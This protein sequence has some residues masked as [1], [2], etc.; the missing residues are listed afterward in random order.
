[1]HLK[2]SAAKRIKGTKEHFK[3][4]IVSQSYLCW[5]HGG[6]AKVNAVHRGSDGV[7]RGDVPNRVVVTERVRERERLWKRNKSYY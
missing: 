5:V 1:M 4:E 3:M 6:Q 2:N 7:Q